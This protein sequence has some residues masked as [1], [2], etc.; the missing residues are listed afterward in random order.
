MLERRPRSHA[1]VRF[2]DCD[3]LGHLNNVQYINYF[4]SA[5][6]DHL[7]TF[8]DLDLYRHSREHGNNWVITNHQISYVRPALPGETVTIETSLVDLSD[9]TVMVEGVMMDE[10]GQ[11]LK[12]LQWTNFRYVSLRTG[13]PTL[14]GPEIMTLMESVRRDGVQTDDMDRRVSEIRQELRQVSVP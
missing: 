10:D 4:V 9:Q 3:L 7:R 1:T 8:Y 13:R 14:H 11:Q 6:E 2:Q 5:R 12:A